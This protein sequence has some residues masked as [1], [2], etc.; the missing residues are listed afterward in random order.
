MA[1]HGLT[2][3][4]VNHVVAACEFFRLGDKLPP[5][6]KGFIAQRLEKDQ[7]QLAQKVQQMNQDGLDQLLMEVRTRQTAGDWSGGGT[8]PAP[9]TNGV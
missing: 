7:P 6:L 8:T 1:I 4:E 9:Q 3:D 2:S 5:A